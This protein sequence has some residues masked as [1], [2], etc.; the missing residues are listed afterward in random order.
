MKKIKNLFFILLQYLLPKHLL[1][2]LFGKLASKELGFFTTFIIKIFIKKYNVDMQLAEHEDPNFYK[3]FNDF[4]TRKL[5]DE[6]RTIVQG[7]KELALPVDGMVSQIGDIKLGRLIQ[8]K[9]HDF[10]LNALIGGNTEDS[11]HFKD[12]KFCTIYLAPKDY[13]RVHMPFDGTLEKMIFVPGQLFSVNPVTAENID[14]LFSRNERVVCI[15]N[16]TIGKMAVILVG[17]TIVASIDTVWAGTVAPNTKEHVIKEYNYQDQNISLK[18]GDEL[19]KFKLGSTVICLFEKDS[20]SFN[21]NLLPLTP[22]Q[23]GQLF[24]TSQK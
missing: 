7:T 14:N 5:K 18:K 8:A 10:G 11:K 16:T 1:S 22:T 24:A 4:F 6:A 9:G 23:F 19:G 15:F 12:G 17:A 13:H 20:I 3:T 2:R 21:E